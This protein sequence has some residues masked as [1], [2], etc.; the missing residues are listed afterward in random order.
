MERPEI[1]RA[2]LDEILPLRS[3]VLRGGGALERALLPGD[4]EG[5]GDHWGA[6]IDGRLVACTSLYEVEGADGSVTTQLRGMAT[7]PDLRNAGIGGALLEA[8][9]A[10]WEANPNRIEPLWCNARIRAVPF[11]GRHRFAEIG[12]PFDV[13]GVGAHLKML[14]VRD[15]A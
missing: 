5:R 4:R 1:R 6:W 11:Y 2:T 3:E 15:A 13:P 14:Y 10:A 8:A 12:E 9:I 7:A